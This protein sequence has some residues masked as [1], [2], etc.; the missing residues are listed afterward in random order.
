MRIG[1]KK[2]EAMEAKM[3]APFLNI[4]DPE[5]AYELPA[6]AQAREDNWYARTPAGPIVLR[7]KEAWDLLG[8]R[9][10]K[11]SGKEYMQMHGVTEGP[12]YD[13]FVNMMANVSIEDHARLRSLVNKVFTP[14]MVDDL[15]P[16]MRVTSQRLSEQI[17][18]GGDVCAFV[19]AFADS[20]ASLVMCEM[21]RVAGGDDYRFHQWSHD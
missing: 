20:L 9:H 10:L 13:W 14:R 8:N 19:S 4:L 16:F 7:N 17:A 21:L 6:V 18:G 11:L 12:L 2:G 5:F 15:R 3:D 1:R